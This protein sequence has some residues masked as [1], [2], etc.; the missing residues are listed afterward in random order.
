MDHEKLADG[1]ITEEAIQR[2]YV[3]QWNNIPMT[4]VECAVEYPSPHDLDEHY[5]REHP[6]MKDTKDLKVNTFKKPYFECKLIILKLQPSFICQTCP[7][8]KFYYNV[9][10]FQEHIIQQHDS[11]FSYSCI[12]CSKVHYDFIK[13]YNHY[14]EVHPSFPTVNSCLVCG[15]MKKDFTTLK[16]HTETHF[17]KWIER[18]RI[19]KE[20]TQP[21]CEV[22]HCEPC[23]KTVVGL[24]KWQTHQRN[25]HIPKNSMCGHVCEI[26]GMKFSSMSM[27][28]Q[29]KRKHE[30]LKDEF[31]CELCDQ[32]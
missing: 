14:A 2:L 19:E 1:T 22:F 6:D 5:K 26:C 25:V 18:R 28:K 32:K 16:K 9:R 10:S 13:L 7:E 23:N 17:G 27:V 21:D 8:S 4:C 29:H 15:K 24:K 20:T 30:D 31:T 11:T 3:K 12:V